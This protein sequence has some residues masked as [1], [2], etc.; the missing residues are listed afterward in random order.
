MSVKVCIGDMMCFATSMNPDI[1]NYIITAII[2]FSPLVIGLTTGAMY[3]NAWDD[4]KYRNLKKP[5]YNPPSYVFGIVWPILYLAIGIIYSYALYDY[6]R[7][8]NKS[9][10]YFK[11]FKY[12]IIPILALLFNFIY[13]PAFFG[14]NGLLNGFIIIIF[15]LVFAIATLLQF[16]FQDNYD[17]NMKYYAILALLPYIIWLSFA[18]ALSFEIYKMN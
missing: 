1:I 3:R 5:S 15:S 8:T 14:E 9:I 13:I 10:I 4:P 12:W 6:R 18:A 2:I 17:P 11:D 16:Y 7:G